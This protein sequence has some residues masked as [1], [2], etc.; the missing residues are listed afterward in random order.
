MW[1]SHNEISNV[2]ASVIPEGAGTSQNVFG[3]LQPSITTYIGPTLPLG[4]AVW[5]GDTG[6]TTRC[7]LDA[8]RI[9]NIASIGGNTYGIAVQQSSYQY[10]STGLTPVKDTLPN[11]TQNRV[12]NNMILDLSSGSGGVYPI[13]MNTA[14]IDLFCGFGFGVQQ[15]DLDQHR[16]ARTSRCNMRSMCSFG[17]TSSRIRVTDSILTFYWLESAASGMRGAIS[18][19]LQPVRFA[20]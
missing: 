9:R 6:N 2:T 16:D 8:N 20:E 1:I 14:R 19:G 10:T 18:S 12:T 17:I 7:W 4:N 13:L 3:I 15:L 11:V 5:P